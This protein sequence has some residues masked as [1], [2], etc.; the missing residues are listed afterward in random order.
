M[1][2]SGYLTPTV[3]FIFHDFFTDHCNFRHLQLLLSV[4]FDVIS[5]VTGYLFF[6]HFNAN[7]HFTAE[8]EIDL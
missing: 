5:D 6:L 8:S 4:Y 2:C 1:T 3:K 7:F